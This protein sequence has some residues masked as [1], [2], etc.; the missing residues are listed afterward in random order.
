[1]HVHVHTPCIFRPVEIVPDLAA[2]SWPYLRCLL[3]HACYWSR[4]SYLVP[5]IVW[6]KVCSISRGG[7][8]FMQGVVL[9]CTSA[10]P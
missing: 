9:E 6:R 8:H 1:M 4:Q 7:L 2:V 3:L 5:V 10:M